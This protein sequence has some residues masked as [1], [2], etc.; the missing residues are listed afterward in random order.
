MCVFM[1]F[2]FFSHVSDHDNC[3]RMAN[4]SLAHLAQSQPLAWIQRLS[5]SEHMLF[6]PTPGLE[7]TAGGLR[8][9]SLDNFTVETSKETAAQGVRGRWV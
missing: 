1:L 8:R 7:A 5:G 2:T 9:V 3:V 6:A 4:M